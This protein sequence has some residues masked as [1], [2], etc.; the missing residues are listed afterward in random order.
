MIEASHPEPVTTPAQSH[1]ERITRLF[2]MFVGVGY[3]GYFA[4]LIGGIIGY[5]DH[6]AAWWSPV[7][8]AAVF[9]SGIAVGVTSRLPGL[10]AMR[11]AGWAAVITFLLAVATWPL[12]WNGGT[13]SPPEG[14][15]LATFPGLAGL[16][17]LVAMPV[18]AVGVYLVV[19]CVAVQTINY[20]ARGYDN[21]WM[22]VP[23]S[24]FALMFCTIF[25]GGSLLALRTGRLLDEA[26]DEAHSSA[27]AAAHEARA[28]ER[29][30]FAALT[31]DRVMSTLLTAARGGPTEMVSP[32]ARTTL[33][34]LDEVASDDGDRP[35]GPVHAVVALRAAA[36]D[37]DAGAGF[38]VVAHRGAAEPIP[39]DVVRAVGGAL[40][41]ALRN[42]VRHA[43][44][45]A[46]RVVRGEVGSDRIELTVS[47]DG[48]GFVADD[49][50]PHRLGIA[51]SIRGRM[52]QL[53]GGDASIKSAPSRG[54]QVRL[55]WAR[56]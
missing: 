19:S 54:T 55:R 2:A 26:T 9:G 3:V 31:H 24:L 39:A 16:A 29:A 14:V 30:R 5:Q 37:A 20:F 8:V 34:E 51:V 40:A 52:H 28:V 35:F 11:I 42:S 18:S 6:V 22:I 47:D 44:S 45:G 48:R 23:E 56:Q 17:A 32:A 36:A 41:E 21:P 1:E 46:H 38:D 15:W 43:G 10:R 53:S 25:A 33:A 4:L 49:V 50:P 27:A 13:V 7:M 12:A